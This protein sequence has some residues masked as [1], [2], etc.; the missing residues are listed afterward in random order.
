MVAAETD[1]RPVNLRGKRPS[2]I[3]GELIEPPTASAP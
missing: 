1:D 3:F 2:E